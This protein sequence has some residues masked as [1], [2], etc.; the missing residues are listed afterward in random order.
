MIDQNGTARALEEHARAQPANARTVE[1][2]LQLLQ[3]GGDPFSRSS[4]EPG[5]FTAS[6]FVLSPNG[7]R[8]L[9]VHHPKLARWL[10]PGGHVE[11]GDTDL[12]AAARREVIEETGVALRGDVRGILDVDVHAIPARPKEGAHSHFD[13]RFVFVASDEALSVSPEVLDA[14]WV[15]LDGGVAALT[16]EESVLRCV[17]QLRELAAPS[18]R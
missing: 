14:R 10:Q 17:A 2:M 7:R 5:H 4:L 18:S 13:V 8:V 11:P 12:A 15:E 3:G 9:L 16:D 1:R 6:G